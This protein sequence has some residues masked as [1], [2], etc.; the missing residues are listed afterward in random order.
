M[1]ICHPIPTCHLQAAAALWWR[2]F[3][4]GPGVPA[5]S[6]ERGV[7]AI[8]ADGGLAGVMGLRDADGGFM[9]VGR[10]LA[11]ILYRPAPPTADLVI[12]GIVAAPR[13]QGVG[14]ALIAEAERITRRRGRCGL[15]AEV[16]LRNAA[17]RAFY[18]RLG[19]LEERRGRFGWPWSGRVVVLRKPLA[20]F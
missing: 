5:A 9:P 18:A 20:A 2:S 10:G 14:H 6:A 4:I 11:R 15:R 7:V 16:Q 13:R 17:A 3:G 8:D 19:F 12:D 1:Q